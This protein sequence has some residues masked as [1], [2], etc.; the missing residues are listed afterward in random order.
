MLIDL[1]VH[2]HGLESGLGLGLGLLLRCNVCE[3]DVIVLRSLV[4]ELLVDCYKYCLM[5]D[6]IQM[7]C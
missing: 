2:V 5:L 7:L 1:H 4:F 3:C 6:C